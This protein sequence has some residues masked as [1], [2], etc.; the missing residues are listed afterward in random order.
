MKP[1]RNFQTILLLAAVFWVNAGN[2]QTIPNAGF[3][4]WPGGV[5]SGWETSN[6]PP[7]YVNVTKS[8]EAHSGA[9]AV[10]GEVI[11][12]GAGFGFPPQVI[13]D[14]GF[15]INF[16][17]AALHG[18]YKTSLMTGDLFYVSVLLYKGDVGVGIGTLPVS[19]SST[20][21][22][23]FVADI[24]YV[25]AETP[26]T[27][28]ISMHIVGLTGYATTGS[29]FIVDDLSWGAATEAKEHET[30]T[31]ARFT[32]KQNYP[33]PLNPSTT[34]RYG[35]PNRSQVTLTVFNTL[36]QQVAQLVNGDMEAGFHEVKFDGSGLSSGVYLYRMQAGSFAETRKL[37]LVK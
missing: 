31:P 11:N 30:G 4:D 5:L 9:S 36:G 12:I 20:V 28:V 8:T 21:Y 13:A 24:V 1:C 15:P 19:T 7:T 33:N 27:A 25:N 32:L 6:D 23:E 18:W 26:D 37:L 10:R 35:L 17:P 34:I 22:R 16:R 3:E 14:P 2:A 29:Y